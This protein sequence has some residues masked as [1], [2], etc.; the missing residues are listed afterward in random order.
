MTLTETITARDLAAAAY[1]RTPSTENAAA[2]QA[3]KAAVWAHPDYV[4][5][6]STPAPAADP[7]R[8]IGHDIGC[9]TQ[10][11]LACDCHHYGRS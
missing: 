2:S 4:R 1:R 7:R 5:P 10:S 9:A 6:A 3:A 11:G 8:R